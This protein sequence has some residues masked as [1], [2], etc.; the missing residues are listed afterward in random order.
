MGILDLVPLPGLPSLALP[1]PERTISEPAPMGKVPRKSPWV[2]LPH[3]RGRSGP[4][5][6]SGPA[7]VLLQLGAACCRVAKPL[8]VLLLVASAVFASQKSFISKRRTPRLVTPLAVQLPL[9]YV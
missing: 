9:L 7:S 2:R 1:R 5:D 8:C 6:G 4:L 3:E